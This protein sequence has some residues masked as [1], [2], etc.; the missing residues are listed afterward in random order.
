MLRHHRIFPRLKS[1]GARDRRWIH[2]QTFEEM[3]D[4]I[5]WQ[6]A[7]EAVRVGEARVMRLETSIRHMLDGWALSPAVVALQAV[8]GIDL[9]TAVSLVVEIGEF[10]RFETAG[11]LMG[12]LGLVP[13]ERSTGEAVRRGAITKMG[14]GRLRQLL[15][16]AAWTYRHPPRIGR[17]KAPLVSAA[18]EAVQEIALKA[19][20]RLCARYRKLAARGKKSTVICT[21]IARELTGFVWAIGRAAMPPPVIAA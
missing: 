7:L 20:T 11:Q 5:V 4:Q 17:M 10:H 6:E 1:W 15:V 21:A 18:P 8:R 3:A 19:Q 12:Y 9:V 14:N 16:E 13:G 2:D